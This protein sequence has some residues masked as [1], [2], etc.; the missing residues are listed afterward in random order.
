MIKT[1]SS[2]AGRLSETNKF[3]LYKKSKCIFSETKLIIHEQKVL[4]IGFG[5][6]E[7]FCNDVIQNNLSLIHI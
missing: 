7:S 3:Y 5:D 1:F 4:D 6:S 2:R